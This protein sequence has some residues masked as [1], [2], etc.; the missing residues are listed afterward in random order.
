M[1]S[2][3]KIIKREP[4]DYGPS[5]QD[6]WLEQYKT[7]VESAER[8]SD[9]RL[10]SNSFF[11]ATNTLLI[12]AES[13]MVDRPHDT[14]YLQLFVGIAGILLCYTWYRMVCAYKDMNTGKFAVIHA[15]EESLPIALYKTEWVALGEGN[16]PQKYRK[17][18]V[19]EM[20]VPWVFLLLHA[21]LIVI[22]LITMSG[23]L[24]RVSGL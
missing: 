4:A 22:S 12:G 18:T 11:L 10:T 8:I 3:L 6:H 15:M 13:I 16:D 24:E 17:F 5:Y 23:G 19:I 7:Y 2:I 20:Y 9:R 1:S 21:A 14:V